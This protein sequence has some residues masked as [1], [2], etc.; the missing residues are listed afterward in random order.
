MKRLIAVIFFLAALAGSNTVLGADISVEQVTTLDRLLEQVRS[1]RASEHKLNA[2]REANF[3]ARKQE[4]AALLKRAEAELAAEERL[5][6]ELEGKF[7]QNELRIGELEKRLAAR[8]GNLGELV[9]V[10]RLAAGDTSSNLENSIV[11]AQFPGRTAQLAKIAKSR[12]L[13]TTEELRA[14]WFSLQK[15]MTETGKVSRFTAPV[16]LANGEEEQRAIVRVG[17]FNALSDGQ[18]L[19]Y[20]PGVGRLA[21]LSRQ[22]AARYLG[23]AQEF[24]TA[25]EGIAPIAVDPTRGALLALLLQAPSLWERIAQGG[26]IGFVIICIALVGLFIVLERAIYL[27][28]MDKRI[29]VQLGSDEAL[30]DNPLGHVI[31]AFENNRDTDRDTLELKLDEAVLQGIPKLERGLP[32]IR[33]LAAVA[34]LLGLLGTVTGMIDTFQSIT[35]FGTGDPKVMAGGISQALVTTALGLITAI[36]LVLMHTAVRARSSRLIHILEEQSA[37]IVAMRAETG[38]K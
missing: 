1:G 17:A 33:V 35:L 22:P 9:G 29:R 30:T 21:E 16:V 34:P 20:L 7:E 24:E 2:E 28:V 11:S 12:E 25:T 6:D 4:Q 36:P 3:L 5:S 31:A 19:T 8:L 13:P 23:L 38:Q 37:G 14:L 10:V 27:F 32:T 26:A 15:E 18:Y